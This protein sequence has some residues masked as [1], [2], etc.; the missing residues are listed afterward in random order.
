MGAALKGHESAIVQA[1][2]CLDELEAYFDS[3]VRCKKRR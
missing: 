3:I 1:E 2:Q